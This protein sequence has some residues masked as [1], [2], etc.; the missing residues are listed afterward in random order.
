MFWQAGAG[1]EADSDTLV[2]LLLAWLGFGGLV[3]TIS[4]LLCSNLG[5]GG[6]RVA[7]PSP[8]PPFTPRSTSPAPAPPTAVKAELPPQ[9]PAGVVAGTDP[10]ATLWVTS[11]GTWLA[12]PDQYTSLLNTWLSALNQFTIKATL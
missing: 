11:L 12:G 5:E 7:P 8:I 9:P 1:G 10:A 3:F 4:H 2:L 6:A